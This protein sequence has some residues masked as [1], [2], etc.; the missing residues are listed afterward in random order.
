LFGEIEPLKA[1]QAPA[2]RQ[3]I[4]DRILNAYPVQS[5]P[6]GE[7]IY[8]LRRDT[9]DP[10][11]ASEYDSPDQHLGKGRLDSPN[12]PILY[13]SKD[14]E[15]CVHECRVRVEDE[16]HIATLVPTRDLNLLDLTEL[17]HEEVTEFESLDHA[18]HMLFFA[19]E[20]SYEISRDI[21]I[22]AHKAGFDGMIYPSYY[23]Q[24]R[25]G[26]MPFETAYGI[27][28]RRFPSAKKSGIFENVDIFGRPISEDL[29]EGEEPQ[30]GELYRAS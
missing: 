29:P 22:A 30:S 16:L 15:G 4:I 17:L 14:I 28:V 18:T 5:L 20:H 10:M 13:C 2:Q 7:T 26:E 6:K 24:V 12:L 23:S 27:S 21:A 3:S 9:Q 8:R 25:S 11:E 19:A 1:L